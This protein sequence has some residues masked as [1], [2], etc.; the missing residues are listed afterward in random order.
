MQTKETAGSASN[1][2]QVDFAGLTFNLDSLLFSWAIMLFILF[3]AYLLSRTLKQRKIG[4][5]QFFFEEIHEIWERQLKSQVAYNPS[6]FLSVVGSIFVFVLFAYW[7]GLLPWKIGLLLE[8]WPLLDNGHHWHG[9]SPV[10]DLN[11]TLGIAIFSTVTYFRAGI[12]S[13][14]FLSYLS[15]YFL[16]NFQ[17]NRF[18]FNLIG[19]IE[20]LD[21]FVR[22]AT[23]SLRLFA[24]TFAG[25][26]LIPVLTNLS[27]IFVFRAIFYSLITIFELLI[28]VLQAFIF[29]ILTVVYISLSCSH[30]DSSEHK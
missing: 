22:P 28:G 13:S 4:V 15:P 24:N 27:S 29:G 2:I 1:H 6:S 8:N 9:A 16:L 7:V 12:K 23:L 3:V 17:K 18:S 5:I 14:G 21:L 11:I 25:E 20:W 10:S 30:N 26:V 19:I